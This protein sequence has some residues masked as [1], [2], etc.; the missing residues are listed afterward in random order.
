M[1]IFMFKF[2]MIKCSDTAIISVIILFLC[3][4]HYNYLFYRKQNH[5]YPVKLYFLNFIR[6]S[7]FWTSRGLCR[8]NVISYRLVWQFGSLTKC[9]IGGTVNQLKICLKIGCTLFLKSMYPFWKK[10][11]YFLERH[12]LFSIHTWLSIK[13]P[14]LIVMPVKNIN[15]DKKK[16][17]YERRILTETNRHKYTW[18]RKR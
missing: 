2:W 1:K 13:N 6:L 11:V 12:V 17:I 15:F 18:Y 14:L 5:E 4:Y 7:S 9:K 3:K 10:D 16:N 8:K